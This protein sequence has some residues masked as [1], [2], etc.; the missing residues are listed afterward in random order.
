MTYDEAIML[1]MDGAKVR[2]A[3]WP[4]DAFVECRELGFF[5]NTGGDAPN[6]V[7]RFTA[8]MP[9]RTATD[10]EEYDTLGTRQD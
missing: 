8:Y 5:L 3:R 10:W 2:R 4:D 1:A 6:P 9:D 7:V